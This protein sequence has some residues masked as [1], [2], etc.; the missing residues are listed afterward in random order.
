MYSE[1]KI[2]ELQNLVFITEAYINIC[3]ISWHG[4]SISRYRL[5]KLQWPK[6]NILTKSFQTLRNYKMLLKYVYCISCYKKNIHENNYHRCVFSYLK[7]FNVPMWLLLSRCKYRYLRSVHLSTMQIYV[8]CS[9]G[10]WNIKNI[11]CRD[12]KFLM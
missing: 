12:K 9:N 2:V 6:I 1:K 11:L 5:Y 10:N 3:Y 4:E 7:Y 8:F